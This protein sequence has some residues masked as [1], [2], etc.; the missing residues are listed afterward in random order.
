MYKVR[1]HI[2]IQHFCAENCYRIDAFLA[3]E[4]NKQF[5]RFVHEFGF[6]WENE[7][8]RAQIFISLIDWLRAQGE[9]TQ[10]QRIFLS[11]SISCLS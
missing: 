3:N 8:V 6:Y 1:S 4:Q 7:M 11:M 9:K 5:F 10:W 2:K